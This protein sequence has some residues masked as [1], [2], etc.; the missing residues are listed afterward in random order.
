MTIPQT[1]TTI[2]LKIEQKVN[3]FLQLQFVLNENMLLPNDDYVYLCSY[4]RRNASTLHAR[5]WGPPKGKPTHTP[6]P[7]RRLR[8]PETAPTSNVHRICIQTPFEVYEYR[9][10]S[11]SR[12]LS[13]GSSPSP[14]SFCALWNRQNNPVLI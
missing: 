1:H 9:M 8:P 3:S 12:L 11:L 5:G 6:R 14:N 7:S 13:N 4:T 2:A 10:E